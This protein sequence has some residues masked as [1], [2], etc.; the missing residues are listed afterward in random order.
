VWPCV[1]WHSHHQQEPGLQIWVLLPRQEQ[2]FTE[3]HMERSRRR[4]YTGSA[5][6]VVTTTNPSVTRKAMSPLEA[7]DIQETGEAWR[8]QQ[9][10]QDS[11]QSFDS[12]R[13]WR[14]IQ[15]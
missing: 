14:F 3:Q 6:G 15:A 11:T 2:L 5:A 1:Q 13:V 4:E 12:H 9:T 10:L 8:P 7:G